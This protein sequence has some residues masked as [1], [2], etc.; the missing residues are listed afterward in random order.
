MIKSTFLA[1]ATAAAAFAAMAVTTTSANAQDWRR[2][3]FEERPGAHKF[4][5][6]CINRVVAHGFAPVSFFGGR[7]GVMKAERRAI[8]SWENRVSEKYGARFANFS[9]AMGKENRCVKNGLDLECTVSAHP[10]RERGPRR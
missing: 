2:G 9:R 5:E 6:F 3:T 4:G 10:C 7:D 8:R 1:V